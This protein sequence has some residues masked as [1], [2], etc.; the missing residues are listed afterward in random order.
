MARA[1]ILPPPPPPLSKHPGAAPGYTHTYSYT[2]IGLFTAEP[3][4]AI[5]LPWAFREHDV[6]LLRIFI[7]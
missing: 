7:F 2:A 1:A 5:G 3:A 6:A 4:G